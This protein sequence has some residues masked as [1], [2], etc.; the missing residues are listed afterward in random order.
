MLGG[1][2]ED[3]IWSRFVFEFV[4]WPQ[5]VTLV[6]W[7]QSAGPLCLWQCFHIWSFCPFPILTSCDLWSSSLSFFCLI[8]LNHPSISWY[9]LFCLFLLVFGKKNSKMYESHFRGKPLK[10]DDEEAMEGSP[11]YIYAMLRQLH[12]SWRRLEAHF[13]VFWTFVLSGFPN[14]EF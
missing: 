9:R 10:H 3:E 11:E 1:D 14:P 7:T 2:S 4:I 13:D 5:E 12:L 8:G 6:R